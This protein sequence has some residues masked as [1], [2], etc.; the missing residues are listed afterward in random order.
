LKQ[1]GSEA[2]LIAAEGPPPAPYVNLTGIIVL[3]AEKERKN[4]N[5]QNF[6]KLEIKAQP[7]MPMSSEDSMSVRTTASSA[8]RFDDLK[9]ELQT[10]INA[11]IDERMQETQ[12]TI[13]QVQRKIAENDCKMEAFERKT[14]AQFNTIKTDQQALANTLQS[15]SEGILGRM[16]SMFQQ[17]QQETEKGFTMLQQQLE[18]R[19]DGND[20]NKRPRQV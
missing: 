15:T 8:T 9:K 12:N 4:P 18:T 14:I 1:T 7:C 11:T 19:G 10:Q 20:E 3:I 13:E 5:L 17:F 16:Q 2:W 6:T